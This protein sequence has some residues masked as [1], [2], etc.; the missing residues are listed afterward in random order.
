MLIS[1]M[2]VFTAISDIILYLLVVVV[3]LAGVAKLRPISVNSDTG[4]KLEKLNQHTGT[5]MI[6]TGL[7]CLTLLRIF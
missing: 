2:A 6:C 4:L 5:A 1:I 7:V 3:I